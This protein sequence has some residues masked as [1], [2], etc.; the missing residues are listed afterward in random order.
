MDKPQ[1]KYGEMCFRLNPSHFE[2]YSHQ[3][4]K[5]N[6]EEIWKIKIYLET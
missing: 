5:L 3:H 1:C 6:S 2:Q 4:C